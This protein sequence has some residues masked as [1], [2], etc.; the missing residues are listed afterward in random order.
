PGGHGGFTTA[1]L[2]PD[3][4]E[5]LPVATEVPNLYVLPTGPVAPNPAELLLS[6]SFQRMLDALA[7]RF[8][9]III[10]SPPL[11]PVTDAAILSRMVDTTMVVVRALRT[12]KDVAK[13][14]VRALRDVKARIAG[15]VLNDVDLSRGEYSYYQYYSYKQEGDGSEEAAA[16][17]R[18]LVVLLAMEGAC[19]IAVLW[20]VAPIHG[21]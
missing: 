8:D 18:W 7:E 20:C 13:Q 2:D 5:S 4:L 9:R 11:V 17:L 6:A 3:V 1:L 10:D 16:G 14:A 12:R 19:G 15:A 21:G